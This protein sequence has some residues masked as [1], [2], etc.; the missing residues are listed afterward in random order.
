MKMKSIQTH[1][2]L[3]EKVARKRNRANLFWGLIPLIAPF[4]FFLFYFSSKWIP[5]VKSV[6]NYDNI[7]GKNIA[8]SQI[9]MVFV[10]GGTFNMGNNLGPENEKPLHAVHLKK[11]YISKYE[12]TNKQFCWFLNNYSSEKV[13]DGKYKGEK[14]I[15]D[16]DKNERNWGV[17][18]KEKGWRPSPGYENYPVV[19]VTWYG[20]NEYCKWAGGRLPS[21]AEWEYAARGGNNSKEYIYSGS[22]D[23]KNVAWY[24]INSDIETHKIGTKSPNELGIYDMSGNVSEWCEDWFDSNYYNKSPKNNPVNL[25]KSNS[26]VLRGGSYYNDNNSSITYTRIGDLPYK[27]YSNFGFRLCRNNELKM[28]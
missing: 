19:Y 4:V 11:F 16:S 15:Y 1:K 2:T 7:T 10:K 22:N 27:Y 24:S 14:M 3:E 18:Y 6:I 21:E 9:E 17:N 5:F 8:L 23:I 28:N 20:A 13:K 12:I 25:S 26:K